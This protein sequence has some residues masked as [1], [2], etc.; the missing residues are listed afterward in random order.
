MDSP[1]LPYE[2]LFLV[3]ENIDS[4][5]VEGHRTL[6]AISLSNRSLRFACQDRMFKDVKIS[7]LGPSFAQ[8]MERGIDFWDGEL[9]TGWKFRDLLFESPHI[10]PYVERLTI[11]ILPSLNRPQGYIASST[12]ATFSLYDIGHLLPNLKKFLT[13]QTGPFG[14]YSVSE[15][16]RAFFVTIASSVNELDLRPF[17]LVPALPTFLCLM[18]SLP[19]KSFLRTALQLG[20]TLV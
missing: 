4:S 18:N 3:I 5:S 10:R 8:D 6:S 1:A 19:V 15:R 12:S 14:W 17:R 9:T 7:Y 2:L 20:V 11:T 13:F 16:I